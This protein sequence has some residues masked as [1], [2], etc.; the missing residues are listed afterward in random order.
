MVPWGNAVFRWIDFVLDDGIA[1]LLLRSASCAVRLRLTV[2]RGW[3]FCCRRPLQL[4]RG[5]GDLLLVLKA[6]NAFSATTRAEVPRQP[7][8]Q[9]AN[10]RK[11]STVARAESYPETSTVLDVVQ[12]CCASRLSSFSSQI[13][14]WRCCFVLMCTKTRSDYDVRLPDSELVTKERCQGDSLPATSYHY[15]VPQYYIDFPH[16]NEALWR[17]TLSPPG[18]VLPMWFHANMTK[19]MEPAP[20]AARRTWRV[21]LA[22]LPEDNQKDLRSGLEGLEG[23]AML[24]SAL[25]SARLRMQACVNDDPQGHGHGKRQKAG[26]R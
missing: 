4:H 2:G 19:T 16:R 17:R 14:S 13:A 9:R 21:R 12:P 26:C 6:P 18:Q 5:F 7:D 11:P 25:R 24:V 15:L 1:V 10:V 23:L 20:L 22:V 3:C 8:P